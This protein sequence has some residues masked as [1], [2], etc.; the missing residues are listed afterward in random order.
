MP[1][2]TTQCDF[3]EKEPDA[4]HPVSATR[5]PRTAHSILRKYYLNGIGKAL[6]EGMTTALMHGILNDIKTDAWL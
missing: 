4:L 3:H 2:R 5:E 6:R 1:S